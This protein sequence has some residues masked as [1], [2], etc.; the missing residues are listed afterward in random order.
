MNQ[1]TFFAQYV[2]SYFG[3]LWSMVSISGGDSQE[4]ICTKLFP[5]SC[6]FGPCSLQLN[7]FLFSCCSAWPTVSCFQD[8][9]WQEG[10]AFQGGALQGGLLQ[11]EQQGFQNGVQGGTFGGPWG[12]PWGG[13]AAGPV[14]FPDSPYIPPPPPREAGWDGGAHYFPGDPQQTHVGPLQYPYPEAEG[15]GQGYEGPSQR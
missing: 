10:G 3:L 7:W 9:Y 6:D 4:Y 15:F 13:P 1:Q 8:P 14:Y 2:A 12:G 5:L 11:G